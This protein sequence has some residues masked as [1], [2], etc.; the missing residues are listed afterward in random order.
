M[1]AFH[2]HP[3]ML[4]E[5]TLSRVQEGPE[6]ATLAQLLVQ[7]RAPNV[8]WRQILSAHTTSP[9]G[10][11]IHLG[12]PVHS[13]AACGLDSGVSRDPLTGLFHSAFHLPNTFHRGDGIAID[14]HGQGTS[15]KDAQQAACFNGLM[16][17]LMIR[18]NEVRLVRMANT[19]FIRDA[20]FALHIRWRWEA[21]VPPPRAAAAHGAGGAPAQGAAASSSSGSAAAASSAS[22]YAGPGAPA[23]TKAPPPAK[24]PP[25]VNP[26]TAAASAAASAHGAASAMP[27]A[28][29]PQQQ[30]Q[31]E[32][33]PNMELPAEQVEPSPQ[34][35]SCSMQQQQKQELQQLVA[36]DPAQ[37]Q[38]QQEQLPTAASAAAAASADHRDAPVDHGGA[39]ATQDSLGMCA[40]PSS[41][42]LPQGT[43]TG[44]M[45]S[46]WMFLS[47]SA[48]PADQPTTG[49]ALAE[50]V[51]AEAAPAPAAPYPW[52]A[53]QMSTRPA[54]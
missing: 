16:L 35:S 44:S 32:Q 48:A 15:A 23:Q 31:Q 6:W 28:M 47:D 22:G 24:A 13:L 54:A 12:G 43:G 19:N 37:Q 45:A 27:A 5:S 4:H 34:E 10:T 29:S 33:L 2:P 30:Q 50:E 53:D 51:L 42:E 1:A 14:V 46:S 3:A 49:A 26:R 17:L 21:G 11:A 39:P 18:P 36:D 52:P 9:P 38:Q 40:W 25:P 20:A 8:G 7:H 41:Q